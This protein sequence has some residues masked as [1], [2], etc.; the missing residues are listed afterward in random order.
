MLQ[1]ILLIFCFLFLGSFAFGQRNVI[2]IIAD[3]LGS[4]YCGF[5][6]NHLDTCKLPNIRRLLAR[7]V[8]FRNAW[9]N[10]LCSPTR[11]GILTGRY[12]FRT[13]VGEAIGGTG[14]AVLDT[15]EITIPRLLNR[16]AP[17][18]IAKAQIGKWHLQNPMPTTNYIFP[19][20]M[21]YDHYEGNFTAMVNNYYNW[22]KVK[23]GVASNITTYATTETTNNAI[24]W[25]KA[26]SSNKPFFL[27]L[28]FN[29]PHTPY[30]AP[31]ANLH[32]YGNLS[33]TS[34]DI[35]ANPKIYF[36][37]AVEAL[38]HEI[39]RL[40]DSLQI[41]GKWDNTDFIF[42]G[43]NGDEPNVA[44]NKGGAKGSVYQEGISV[45]FIISGPSVVNPNRA[46]DALVNTTDLFATILDLF[47]YSN[48]SRE[49]PVNKPV[50]S[51]SILPILKNQATDIRSWI[52]T[53]VFKK[54]TVA[55]DGKAIRN[56]TYKLLNFDNGAQQFYRIASDPTE[57]T[58]L[59]KTTLSA[60]A[61]NNYNYLC[62]E[63]TNLIG[64]SGF[65]S[66][67]TPT[68]DLI[69]ANENLRIY[70]NPVIDY[71][72]VEHAQGD[73]S[74]RVFNSL[75]QVLFSGNGVEQ[76]NL[77]GLSSG[78]YYL[79]IISHAKVVLRFFKQ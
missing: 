4:D 30:H 65:C 66:L 14:S 44:Q 60:E 7:G 48:W 71:L 11:A 75:G 15:A 24:S 3:D 9:S 59:L 21:G 27:W 74:F 67:T 12:S 18:A 57:D 51:K 28:A 63:M 22:T 79:E 76:Q 10:P 29:A 34:A 69:A 38:D 8:R 43:D 46:S 70:P 52:F 54:P 40:F 31:P 25:I 45:P 72:K 62:T 78:V 26:Q 17:N 39:G 49:I 73:E 35:T 58:D 1:K 36:K 19:N 68:K 64:K 5:Y 32:S 33:G 41:M 6:E 37:A 61:L 13:G 16:F 77:S 53:E 20:R 55:S 50:D 56:K 23:N 47:G 42:I 2:L